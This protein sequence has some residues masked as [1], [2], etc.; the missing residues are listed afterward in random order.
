VTGVQTCALPICEYK[1]SFE[2]PGLGYPVSRDQLYLDK[3][4]KWL[5]D[6]EIT[7][8]IRIQ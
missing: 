8:M 4:R 3:V 1:A 7:K 5:G 2:F 6:I